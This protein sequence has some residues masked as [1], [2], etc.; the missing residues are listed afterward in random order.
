MTTDEQTAENEPRLVHELK[1]WPVY[2]EEVWWDRKRFEVRYDDRG[3]QVGDMLRLR[4]YS[5]ELKCYTGRVTERVVGYIMRD[6]V[7][8]APGY[9]VLGFE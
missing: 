8:L 4:E 2:F 7:G 3:F 9:V 1:T 6:F 5:P